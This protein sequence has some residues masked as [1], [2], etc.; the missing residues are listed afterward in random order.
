MLEME[1][2]SWNIDFLYSI[3]HLTVFMLWKFFICMRR[4]KKRRHIGKPFKGSFS[5]WRYSIFWLRLR[6][7][8]L[9]VFLTSARTLKHKKAK[10][11][12]MHVKSASLRNLHEKID[13]TLYM[14]HPPL[15]H[16][17]LNYIAVHWWFLFWFILVTT[18]KI[19]IWDHSQTTL[20]A[21]RGGEYTDDKNVWDQNV[22]G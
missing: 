5:C 16:K 15:S 8:N 18:E 1:K 20:T 21:R 13:K 9:A 3:L 22:M 17:P 14:T 6:H 11:Y 10:N 2:N 19:P 7:F 12:P 4:E